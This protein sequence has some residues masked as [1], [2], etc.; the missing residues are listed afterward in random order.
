M[1][2]WRGQDVNTM[3]KEELIQALTE[4]AQ[5]YEAQLKETTRRT[6]LLLKRN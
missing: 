2:L 1:K 3:T 6:E 4:M 5:L